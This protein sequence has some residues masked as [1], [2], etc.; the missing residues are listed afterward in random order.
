[1]V[2]YLKH[3]AHVCTCLTAAVTIPTTLKALVEVFPLCTHQQPAQLYHIYLGFRGL[4]RV[5]SASGC[6]YIDD[7]MMV[8][9]IYRL[10]ING[11]LH[12]GTA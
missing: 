3:I 2:S 4:F 7:I 9:I 10:C 8:M 11:W 5:Y 12:V 6:M 1:M